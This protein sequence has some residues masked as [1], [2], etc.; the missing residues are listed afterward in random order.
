MSDGGGRKR[1]DIQAGLEINLF[2]SILNF[3]KVKC[4]K[5]KSNLYIF[6]YLDVLNLNKEQPSGRV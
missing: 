3:I 4:P 5:K 2:Y 6:L 1:K